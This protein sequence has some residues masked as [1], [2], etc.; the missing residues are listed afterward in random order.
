MS[1][2]SW[3]R[4]D[5]S[6]NRWQQTYFKNFVDISGDLYIRKGGIS[7]GDNADKFTVNSN[8]DISANGVNI[9]GN[10]S[11]VSGVQIQ[12]ADTA[13]YVKSND[14]NRLVLGDKVLNGA[15]NNT[16]VVHNNNVGIGGVWTPG[17]KL[18]VNGSIHGDSL[19]INSGAF[20]VSSAGDVHATS[21]SATTLSTDG[22]VGIG[23]TTPKNKLEVPVDSYYDGI[24][25]K[26]GDVRT[27]FGRADSTNAGSIQVFAGVAN[28]TPT[29]SS[30]KYNLS[31]QPLGGN[32]GIGTTAPGIKLDVVG[33]IRARGDSSAYVRLG[34]YGSGIAYV[35]GDH[36]TSTAELAIGHGT[37]E[38]MRLKNGNVGIGTTSPGYKLDIYEDTTDT[39]SFIR[40]SAKAIDTGKSTTYMR[41]ERGNS[42]T[43]N[44]YGGVIGGYLVQGVG[45]GL[46]LGTI[47]AGTVTDHM[48]IIDNGNVGIGTTSPGYKLDVY[49]NVN[50][51]YNSP[52]PTL[53]AAN[54]LPGRL[55][56]RSAGANSAAELYLAT[57]LD[58]DAG[59]KVAIIAQNLTGAGG[60]SRSK[61]M[62]C[63]EN[64][65]DNSITATKDHAR[66]TILPSGAVG[67]GTTT[68][69]KKLDVVGDINFTGDLYKGGSLFNPGSQW[70]TTGNNIYYNTGKVGIGTN[71]PA[72]KLE[73]DGIIQ[74]KSCGFINQN[75]SGWN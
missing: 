29:S 12:A 7:A 60:Y 32:V 67:I 57:P 15:N 68:P 46:A 73:V 9:A 50:I 10:V 69:S 49:G 28:A 53:P 6:A 3:L 20:T 55:T 72:Q 23:T 36:G 74:C 58:N 11:V 56:I 59:H 37:T 48:Y 62:F 19:D 42:G 63:L 18:D 71:N 33:E 30:N 41:L 44:G 14:K 5:M 54:Y 8:G 16:I 13:I 31:L 75:T 24:C 65:T 1:S 70:T 25:V 45:S 43:T 39:E 26:S 21:L 61:L 22:N 66:M 47:G 51:G 64:T 17:A 38:V 40:Y 34:S 52:H 27:I 2:H 35:W 4:T